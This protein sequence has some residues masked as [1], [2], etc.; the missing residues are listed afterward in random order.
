M[1]THSFLNNHLFVCVQCIRPVVDPDNKNKYLFLNFNGTQ[2]T[3]GGRL[4]QRFFKKQLQ[5]N[6]TTTKI[7]SL[8]ETTT[9]QLWK[10]GK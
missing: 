5:L 1:I 3:D 4:V 2:E 7:R 6:L 10:S 9:N 8:F